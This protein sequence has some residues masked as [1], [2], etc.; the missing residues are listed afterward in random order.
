MDYTSIRDIEIAMAKAKC[1]VDPKLFDTTDTLYYDETDNIQKFR[2]KD[3]GFNVAA[4]SHF[5]L[6]GVS[7]NESITFEELKNAWGFKNDQNILEI[8]STNKFVFKGDFAAILKSGKLLCFLELLQKRNCHIHFYNLN[9]LYFSLVDIIDSIN[10]P[11]LIQYTDD[12]K[13]M[14]YIIVKNDLEK[15]TSILYN[16]SYPNIKDGNCHLFI[17]DIISLIENQYE[18]CSKYKSCAQL[19]KLHLQ[20]G[21]TQQRLEFIQDNEDNEPIE[22]IADFYLQK[23]YML[24]FATHIFDNEVGVKEFFEDNPVEINSKPIENFS[25]VDSKDAVM[26][27][28][29]DLVV[30]MLKRYFK[31]VDRETD[32]V[33]SDIEQFSDTQNKSFKFLNKILKKSLDYNPVFFHHTTNLLEYKNFVVLVNKYG[34]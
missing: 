8:K 23:I 29:S 30:A 15:S 13:T 3:T 7:T 22:R 25:F 1:S 2:I 12:L 10:D 26:T 18:S 5:V 20:K 21:L 16:Y 27:Q 28:V 4:D 9:I 31:F 14:L 6:G 24:P 32:L 17:T 33:L 34:N 19:L 11:E